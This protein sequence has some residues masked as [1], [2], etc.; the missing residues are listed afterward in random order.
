MRE[1]PP[2]KKL[3][4][5]ALFVAALFWVQW[6]TGKSKVP[7]W[8]MYGRIMGTTYTFQVIHSQKPNQESFHRLLEKINARFST[9][10]PS[11][12]LSLL[13]QNQS[14]EPISLSTELF[15]VLDAS[16]K[17]SK[18]THG[19]FDVTV[20]PLVNAWGFGP[21]KELKSPSPQDVQNLKTKVGYTFLNLQAGQPP[22]TLPTLTKKQKEVWC[23]LSAIAKGYAV[24]QIAKAF[25]RK[26][27]TRYWVE[28]GGEVRV[29]GLN[30][31]QVPWRVGIE[32]PA[33]EGRRQIYKVIPL[34]DQSLAT[35]GEYRNFYIEETGQ[36]RSHTIDP[37]TGEPIKHHLASVSV[38]HPSNMYADAW[39]T[40]LNVLGTQEGLKIANQNQIAA[41]FL[42]YSDSKHTQL[43]PVLSEKMK[44]YLES[45]E[46]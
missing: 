25:D 30:A 4:I 23:D 28:I 20:G 13:N 5:P 34:K 16:E 29:K 14:R 32:K 7:L 11:S 31:D 38:L 27:Y 22:S 8:R 6:Q 15:S 21:N 12:E 10:L 45:V 43:Q 46:Q 2:L 42:E 9:Y 44:S 39:A 19:A 40:A 35:S 36:R 24:D 1:V 18:A 17:V 37:R 26:G 3:I 41:F 33:G